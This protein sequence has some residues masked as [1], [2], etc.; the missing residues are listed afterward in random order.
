MHRR[1]RSKWAM[2]RSCDGAGTRINQ[3]SIIK[4]AGINLQ[5]N[6]ESTSDIGYHINP[7]TITSRIVFAKDKSSWEN[8]VLYKI[9]IDNSIQTPDQY[10]SG[11]KISN[12]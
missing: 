6:A 12:S 4:R 11:W 8:D 2:M 5:D 3:N 10:A 9:F 7:K 1:M